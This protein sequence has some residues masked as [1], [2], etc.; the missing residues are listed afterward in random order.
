[1]AKHPAKQKHR[2]TIRPPAPG[3]TDTMG[4]I[5]PSSVVPPSDQFTPITDIG[6]MG[7]RI[8]Q[9]AEATSQLSE[10]RTLTQD[11]VQRTIRVE[12]Q[13]K[14]ITGRVDRIEDTIKRDDNC[15]QKERLGRIEADTSSTTISVATTNERIKNLANR[16]D[17]IDK[18]FDEFKYN[19][20]HFRLQ[21]FIALITVAITTLTAAGSGLWWISKLGTNVE[22]D[23]IDN[24]QRYKA[25]TDKL[26]SLDEKLDQSDIKKLISQQVANSTKHYVIEDTGLEEWYN[27]LTTREKRSLRKILSSSSMSALKGDQ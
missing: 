7:T 6:A 2:P 3:H 9:I 12:E 22:R 26:G 13:L 16:A 19:R 5:M 18:D 15:V 23:R 17:D 4:G 14:A 27:S 10:I 8:N 11:A 20:R 1:M 21:F 24:A 25:I